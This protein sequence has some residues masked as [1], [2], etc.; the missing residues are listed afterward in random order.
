MPFENR[1]FGCSQSLVDLAIYPTWWPQKLIGIIDL[2]LIGDDEDW[3]AV[4]VCESGNLTVD[5]LFS[6]AE[7]D[8]DVG[9][10]TSTGGYIDGSLSSNDNEQVGGTNLSGRVHIRIHG[11]GDDVS[12]DLR[13][14]MICP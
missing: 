5:V 4:D 12:Y 11:Y 3:I 2:N 6:H 8:I 14:T 13:I 7:G 9:L 1:Y 10:T